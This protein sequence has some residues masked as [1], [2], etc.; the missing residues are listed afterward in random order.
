MSTDFK[1]LTVKKYPRLPGRKTPESRY[2]RKFKS[3]IVVKEFAA[4]SSV[5][6]SET[7]PY[8]FAVTASTRVQIYSS[9]THQVKKTIS[10]FKD[11]AYSGT[12][13]ADGKLVVAGDA[14]GL[15]QIFDVSSRAI[16]RTFREHKHPVHVTKFSS[17]KTQILSASDDKTVRIWDMPSETPLTIFTGHEDYIRSGMVSHDN[18]HLI[19]SGSY[20]QTVKLWDMRTQGCVMT[21]NHGSPVEAVEM[22]PDGGVVVSAGG[23]SIK[24]FDILAGGRPMHALSNHQKTVTSLCFDN[25]HSR[26]LTGSLDQHVK[27]YN[28][29]DYS[30]VHSVKYPAPVLSVALSPDDT[31]LVAGMAG[32]LLSIRQRV[33]KTAEV[34][35]RRAQEE[36]I[37]AGSYKYFV[38]GQKKANEGDF[39]VETQ[40]KRRLREY[41]R[42]L[43][44]F[45]Y[46]NALDACLRTNQPA[47]TTVSLIQELVH[48]DGLRQALS[49]R[50]DISLEPLAQFLVRNINNPRYT[51]I[52]VD[53]TTIMIDMYTAVL[54]Q[55]P[56]ID[57]LFMRLRAKVKMEIEFQKQLLSVLGSMEM[58]FAKSTTT[59]VGVAIHNEMASVSMSSPATAPTGATGASTMA[60]SLSSSSSSRIQ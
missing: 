27:I 28:V 4:V 50:D 19:L 54:G 60:S 3:P 7:T 5:H 20:D 10:R 58:L 35:T 46:G 42:Y 51:S 47:V 49:G 41:D 39:T 16:L 15:I 37:R 12:I 43:K 57:E 33:V 52:L 55:S 14:T 17:D 40:R 26:L 53:V 36:Q 45:Q 8:D 31:H 59:S 25:S 23:P 13:R 29:Q 11:V 1:S 34:Q 21:M 2:W 32:G 18:P 44:A 48:R 30:V 38:R 24:V 9:K 22:F 56:L 6:F